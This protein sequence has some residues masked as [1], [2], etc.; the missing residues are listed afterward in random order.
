MFGRRWKLLSLNMKKKKLLENDTS[1]GLCIKAVEMD[2]DVLTF[3]K[4]LMLEN[5]YKQK[6]IDELVYLFNIVNKEMKGGDS[7][8]KRISGRKDKKD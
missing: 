8:G 3:R 4:H 5:K 7:D 1:V 2:F 6:D